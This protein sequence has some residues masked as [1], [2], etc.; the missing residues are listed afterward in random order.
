MLWSLFR[1]FIYREPTQSC[2][3]KKNRDF[4]GTL[5]RWR[6]RKQGRSLRLKKQRRKLRKVER[7]KYLKERVL[8]NSQQAEKYKEWQEMRYSFLLAL[9][10]CLL[11]WLLGVITVFIPYNHLGPHWWFSGKESS[12][13]CRWHSSI[14]GSERSPGEGNS[15]AL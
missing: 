3:E 1:E 4:W 12:C 7:Y 10:L 13:Q 6:L 14:P 11:R 8:S 5:T 15:N 2:K 9:K